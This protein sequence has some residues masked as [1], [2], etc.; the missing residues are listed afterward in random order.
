[1]N[2]DAQNRRSSLQ[3]GFREG[4]G[5]PVIDVVVECVA[6]DPTLREGEGEGERERE[7]LCFCCPCCGSEV[8]LSVSF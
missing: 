7:S 4:D 6:G 1:M 3:L 2:G 5:G 8:A